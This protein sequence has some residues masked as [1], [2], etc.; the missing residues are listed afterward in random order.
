MRPPPTLRSIVACWIAAALSA[1]ASGQIAA[2]HHPSV[3][4]ATWAFPVERASQQPVRVNPDARIMAGF[5]GRVRDYVSLRKKLGATLPALP[6]DATPEQIETHRRELARLIG[7]A[8]AS[9]Q[10]G[11]IF[12]KET[13]ALFRRQLVR[14]LGGPDGRHLRA[15]IRDEGPAAL[16]VKLTVN[17]RYPDHVPLSTVPP[18]VLQTLPKLPEE[19][20]YRFVGDA[21]ILLDVH[22]NIV[23]DIIEKALPRV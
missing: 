20:E 11:D 14:V 7:R 10:P 8:R 13:R 12:T 1:V 22:A 19:L 21:L 6:N 2:P 18:Q 3:N 5:D 4:R 9:A 15:T 23:I 16:P 17:S